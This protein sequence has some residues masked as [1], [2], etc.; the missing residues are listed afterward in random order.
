MAERFESLEAMCQLATDF[1][2]PSS[3]GGAWQR[4]V[5]SDLFPIFY[6]VILLL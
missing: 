6:I 3:K 5:H 4:R 1:T 2:R